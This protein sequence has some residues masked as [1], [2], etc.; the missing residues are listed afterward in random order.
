MKTLKKLLLSALSLVFAALAV[1][2]HA[3]VVYGPLDALIPGLL[4]YFLLAFIVISI[5][6]LLIIISVIKKRNRKK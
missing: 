4:P 1:P 3:D 5:I 2:A 6:V